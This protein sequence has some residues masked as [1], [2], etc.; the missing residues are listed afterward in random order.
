M[1]LKQKRHFKSHN[2]PQKTIYNKTYKL[3]W[4]KENHKIRQSKK[5]HLVWEKTITI[6]ADFPWRCVRPGENGTARLNCP[7]RALKP[8]KITFKLKRNEIFSKWHWLRQITCW[9]IEWV[10]IFKYWNYTKYIL[11]PWYGISSKWIYR[12][13]TI[14]K[15]SQELIFAETDDLIL[16]IYLKMWKLW[17]SQNSFEKKQGQIW[18]LILLDSKNYHRVTEL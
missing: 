13:N 8:E 15:I 11:W 4:A 17:H 18:A 16:K 1:L 3:L 10:T 6:R 14:E 5:T 9:A 7:S 12:A 2:T